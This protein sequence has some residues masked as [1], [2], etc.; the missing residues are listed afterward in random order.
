MADIV[1]ILAGLS[2]A[3]WLYLA[4]ARRGFWRADQWLAD[5]GEPAGG[6]PAVAAV[7]PARD[8]ADVIARSIGSILAQDYPGEL[9]VILVDDGSSD[10]TGAIARGLA[11]GAGR[12]LVVLDGEP[13][14]PGWAGKLWAVHQGVA[15]ARELL[16]QHAFVWLTDADIAHRP[17]VLR[18]LAGKAQADRRDLVSL[19]ALLRCESGWEKLLIPAFVFFFQKLY[20]F[21]AV[22]DPAGRTA[23]A[24]G[25][26][27]L[28]RRA[29]LE[30]AGGIAAIRGALI[31]DCA[32]AARVRQ[33]GG[34]LWLGLTGDVHSLRPYPRLGDVWDMVARSAYT[35]LRHSPWLLAGTLLGMLLLYLV[36][37]L[38][39]LAWP[40]HGSGLAAGLGAAAWL[41]MAALYRPTLRLYRRPVWEGFRLPVAGLLYA[42]MTLSSA[43][44]HWRGRGGRWKGRLQ[45]R[46]GDASRAEGA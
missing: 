21:P 8:E 17:G 9:A 23:A 39:L 5:P 3:A 41:A 11:A 36:P 2:A 12:R 14:P 19:M 33:S 29:G 30:R 25:G 46:A 40:L 34:R 13:L 24:A 44:R 7:V 45:A 1:I 43:L 15:A 4:L 6:W 27:V 26:C 42:L 20:P 31:D 32:L 35:Q 22:N 16:P 38:A 18:A 10:G 37:P 28:L